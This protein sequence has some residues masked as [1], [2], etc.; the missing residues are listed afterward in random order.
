MNWRMV[1]NSEI[2]HL[3]VPQRFFEYAHAYRNAASALCLKMT[4][5][6]SSCTW[7]NSAVVLLLAAH[8]TELFIKGAI[9]CHDPTE[10]IENHYIDDLSAKYRKHYPEP[11]FEW[12]I[13]FKTEYFGIAETEIEA[14]KKMNPPSILYRY[15][16]A[17]GCKE[18][19]GAFGFE[20]H[21]FLELLEQVKCD[22]ERIQGIISPKNQ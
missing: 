17:R 14:L 16:V 21:S 5:E 11:L 7:P 10:I 22:F 4:S 2:H 8:S 9:L 12:D 3:T 20:P 1:T 13:P 18:W 19:N 15:P 6:N